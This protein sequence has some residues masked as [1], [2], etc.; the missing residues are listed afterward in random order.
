MKENY[1]NLPWHSRE[2]IQHNYPLTDAE[3]LE[4]AHEM[5]D[6]RA[7]MSRLEFELAGIKKEYKE[8]IDMCAG[9]LGDAVKKFRSGLADP[10]EV[11]CDV[12]QDFDSQEMVYVPVEENVELCRRPMRDN[13]KRPDLMTIINADNPKI[14]QFPKQA[15]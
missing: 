13:E 6:A 1:L 15:G 4:L 3:K 5:A 2:I 11:E 7:E 14:R 12:Y 9:Q 8:R 10:V